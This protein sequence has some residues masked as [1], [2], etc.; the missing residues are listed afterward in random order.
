MR[1]EGIIFFAS[2]VHGSGNQGN[3]SVEDLLFAVLVIHDNILSVIDM[4]GGQAVGG[5]A[6]AQTIGIVCVSCCHIVDGGFRHPVQRSVF[7]Q[8]DSV[9][10]LPDGDRLVACCFAHGRDGLRGLVTLYFQPHYTLIS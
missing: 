3:P 1:I 5:F 8:L 7:K 10:P 4:A 2:S 9:G 6:L